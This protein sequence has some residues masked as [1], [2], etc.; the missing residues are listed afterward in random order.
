MDKSKNSNK[1]YKVECLECGGIIDN[2]YVSR[3]KKAKHDGQPVK[4][5]RYGLPTDPFQLAH[6]LAQSKL[7]KNDDKVG[8]DS[9]ILFQIF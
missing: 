4:T 1:R 6:S 7:K 3:H 9:T 8:T 2:D 5:R